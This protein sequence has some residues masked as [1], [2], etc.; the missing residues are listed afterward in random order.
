[1]PIYFGKNKIG[2]ICKI[3]LLTFQVITRLQVPSYSNLVTKVTEHHY[4]HMVCMM[5]LHGFFL[6]RVLLIGN[7]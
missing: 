7:T 1:M 2:G 5:G 4:P 6:T 3:N